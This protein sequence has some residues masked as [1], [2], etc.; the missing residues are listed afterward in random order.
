MVAPM[1]TYL[2][3]LDGSEHAR[4]ALDWARAVATQEEKVV[5]LHANDLPIV[6]GLEIAATVDPAESEEVSASSSPGR[7]AISTTR[8]STVA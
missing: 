5:V 2:V 1:T 7:S 6:T 3:G 4:D 8:G